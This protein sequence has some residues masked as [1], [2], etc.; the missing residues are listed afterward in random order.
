MHLLKAF[1]LISLISV[2]EVDALSNET[3]LKTC[4]ANVIRAIKTNCTLIISDSFSDLLGEILK[5]TTAHVY[6]SGISKMRLRSLD[7]TP[8]LYVIFASTTNNYKRIVEKF[9]RTQFWNPRA[10]FFV[11]YTGVE[12]LSAIFKISWDFFILNLAILDNAEK[13]YSYFPFERGMCGGFDAY[14]EIYSCETVTDLSNG[15][16]FNNRLPLVFNGCPVRILALKVE[17]HVIDIEDT[18]MPGIE[19]LLLR[20]VAAR[21]NLSLVFINHNFTAWGNKFADGTYSLMYEELSKKRT[22]IMVGL[23][24]ANISLYCDFDESV[25]YNHDIITFFVPTAK[26]IDSWRNFM[27][28]FDN[29]VWLALGVTLLAVPL[30]W[31]IIGKALKRPNALDS[32][33]KCVFHIFEMLF[34]SNGIYQTSACLKYLFY[35]W[36]VFCLMLN[37]AY[38]TK[39]TSYLTK[40]AYEHQISTIAEMVDAG[41]SYGGFPLLR[42]LMN[43]TGNEVY[44]KVFKNFVNC[45]LT[46][47]CANRSAEKRDFGVFKSVKIINYLKPKIYTY[48]DG[49]PKLF[50]VKDVISIYKVQM[51]MIRGL[52]FY[53][54]INQLIPRIVENGLFAKWS[55]DVESNRKYISA[56]EFK[57]L[58]VQHL[59]IVFIIYILGNSVAFV[60]F[61]LEIVYNYYRN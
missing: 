2:N 41:L 27:H 56:N 21:S 11:I 48:P 6:I 9:Y 40:P 12:K 28:V 1:C 57:Q 19:I 10:K 20:E 59:K 37:S 46:V 23:V 8:T 58:T 32:L 34:T 55:K 30:T 45:P 5:L 42:I 3:A 17:P 24:I 25:V 47:E 51:K 43:E 14:R 61:L 16:L 22:D 38:Q 18:D 52:P 15:V 35:L 13:V 60:E 49:R 54:R 26:M 39:L 31:W 44:L 50:Q 4:T 33:Q 53:E 29:C 36:C 7:C